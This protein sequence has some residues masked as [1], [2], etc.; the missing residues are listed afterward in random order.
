MPSPEFKPRPYGIAINVTNHEGRSCRHIRRINDTWPPS[1]RSP[2]QIR[3][4]FVIVFQKFISIS[5]IKNGINKVL[6]VRRTRRLEEKCF[7]SDEEQ[8][9]IYKQNKTD[10]NTIYA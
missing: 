2:V 1:Y 8:T 10:R 3:T 7:Q 9:L 5:Y 6:P 4:S